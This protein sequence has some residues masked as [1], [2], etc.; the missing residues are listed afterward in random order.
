MKVLSF[1]SAASV[2]VC[3]AAFAQPVMTQSGHA[4]DANPGMNSGRVNSAAAGFV[5]NSTQYLMTGQGA[6][7]TSFRGY[8]DPGEAALMSGQ[9]Q[10]NSVG[11]AA[12]YNFNRDSVNLQSVTQS[13]GNVVTMK[14]QP[15]LDNSLTTFSASRVSAVSAAMAVGGSPNGG[16]SSTVLNPFAQAQ[17]VSP[18]ASLPTATD[19]NRPLFSTVNVPTM[20]L[21]EQLTTRQDLLMQTSTVRPT[22]QDY[23]KNALD[24]QL[25]QTLLFQPA[26]P[27]TTPKPTPTLSLS[28]LPEP[29]VNKVEPA[30][31]MQELPE[32]TGQ[33]GAIIAPENPGSATNATPPGGKANTGNEPGPTA[34]QGPNSKNNS[35]S[36]ATASRR[37]FGPSDLDLA[38]RN[39]TM[40]RPGQD[41]Y[42]DLLQRADQITRQQER[43]KKPAGKPAPAAGADGAGKPLVLGKPTVPET[44]T[45]QERL[46]PTGGLFRELTPEDVGAAG[47]AKG[48]KS[49]LPAP[50]VAPPVVNLQVTYATYAGSIPS[51]ANRLLAE[52]EQLLWQ[53]RFYDAIGDLAAA[54]AADPSNPLIWLRSCQAEV[55]A[56]EYVAAAEDLQ[57]AVRIFPSIVTLRGPLPG[58]SGTDGVTRLDG[59]MTELA[60]LAEQTHRADLWMLMCYMRLATDRLDAA[61]EAARQ[62]VQIGSLNPQQK[63]LVM[64]VLPPA[65]ASPTTAPGE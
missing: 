32:I 34:E 63:A 65:S 6:L 38:A 12:L 24:Q 2:L 39:K 21:T 59:R 8:V 56:G 20:P 27:A 58:L 23:Q 57:Q 16:V 26:P 25:D 36:S 30:A 31:K 19:V 11:S 33:P 9:F 54:R 22:L 62:L 35:S 51:R 18:A 61:R 7:G 13:G 29:G 44:L 52:A 40:L 37:P 53:R 1:I 41:I 46:D 4:L 49:N 14:N 17:Y 28:P 55:A 10:G 43:N 3:G 42:S 64:F 50:A 60:R 48:N 47:L 45:P 5:P 15:Y